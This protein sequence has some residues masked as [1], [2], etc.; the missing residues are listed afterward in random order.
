QAP[1]DFNP[2]L[3]QASVRSDVTLDVDFPVPVQE[4]VSGVP[5]PIVAGLTD[6]GPIP[7]SAAD[8][9]ARVYAPTGAVYN[10][11]LY[12]DGA[13]GDGATED[14][15]YANTF[16]QT[17]ASGSDSGAGSY[18]VEV[19][20]TGTSPLA[21]S[22]TRQKVLGFFIFSSADTD[23]DG[24]PPEWEDHFGGNPTVLD[25]AADPDGDGRTTGEEFTDG[26]DPLDPDSDD[27]GESDGSEHNRPGGPSDPHD[28]TD[29]AVQPT[30]TVAYPGVSKVFVRY[31]PRAEYA[32]TQIWKSESFSGTYTLLGEDLT[33]SGMLTDTAVTNG[34]D[35]CYYAIGITAGGA[36]SAHMTPSC[37]TPKDDPWPPDGALLINNGASATRS[38]HVTLSLFASDQVEL[39]ADSP[40]PLDNIMLPPASSATGVTQMRISNQ[41]DMS[42][43][44]W[45]PFAN[46]KDW[47]L[48]RTSGLASVYVQYRDAAGN[49][50]RIIPDSIW[51][52]EGPGL[53]DYNMRIPVVIKE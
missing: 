15:V 37:A 9:N 19:T 1:Q 11:H 4:R 3:V 21:G 31:A 8:V 34:E 48:D 40:D 5:M 28:P 47:T 2:Y 13:H 50:S 38:P 17:G 12:D 14:G 26:T 42:G 43:A 52:N 45:E 10:L 53:P 29:D 22:F 35:Y 23:G 41:G 24:L 44:Q 30:W 6:T 51:V 36:Q 33:G 18:N 32:L 39:H 46:S 25:P 27:G 49:E 7:D 20:A 16:Y